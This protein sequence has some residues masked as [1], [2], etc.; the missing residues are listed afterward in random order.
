MLCKYCTGT[1]TCCIGLAQKKKDRCIKYSWD[2]KERCAQVLWTLKFHITF[3]SNHHFESKMPFQK[4]DLR[5]NK[6]E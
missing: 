4:Q 1:W 5:E 6:E 3:N 2:D